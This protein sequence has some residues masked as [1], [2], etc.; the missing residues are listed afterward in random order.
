MAWLTL[1]GLAL[2]LTCLLPGQALAEGKLLPHQ[3]PFGG[4]AGGVAD[5]STFDNPAYYYAPVR[6]APSGTYYRQAG[7]SPDGAKIV[8][9]KSWNDGTYSRTEIV[10]MDAD[11]SDE[12]VISPGDSGQ[13]DIEQYGNPF[14]SDDG[15][16]VGYVE[17]HSANPNKVVRYDLATQTRAYI[18]E[19]VSPLDANNAD[20]L[21]ASTS[22]LVFWDTGP[23]TPVQYDLFTWD[24]TTRVNI[25]NSAEYK[26]YEPVSNADGTVIVYWSGET[27]AE[28][29]NT[30]HTLTYAGGT[31]TKDVGFSPIS[32]SY[33]SGW[34]GKA[35]NYIATTV[36]SSKDIMI[37][38]SSGALVTDLTGSGYSGGTGQWN[39]FGVLAEGPS[40]NWV[41]TSNAA[42]GATAGRDIVCAASRQEMYVAPPPLG[43]DTNCGTEAA[44]F[45]TVQKGVTEVASGGTVHV[46]AGTYTDPLLVDKSLALLGP[47][48]AVNP[49]TGARVAEAVLMGTTP[50]GLSNF[51]EL[52]AEDVVIRGFTFDNLRIDN[53]YG[54]TGTNSNL[55]GG[56]VIENNIFSDV[57]G[58][59]IYLRDG[60]DAPGLYSPDVSIQGNLIAAPG[61]AGSLD[62]QAGSGIVV[63]GAEASTISGNVVTSAAYNG[64]QLAR[65]NGMSVAD[66]TATGCAQPALQIAQWNDGTFTITGN[67]FST[68]STAKAAIRLYGFTNNYYP[69]FS[70]TGNT[71]QDSAYGA[72]IG[73]GDPGKGYNDIRDADYSFSGNTFSNVTN[74]RLIVYLA[75]EA[76][77][78]ELAEMDALFEQ[79]YYP[80]DSAQLITSADPFTYVVLHPMCS[81]DCYVA[82]TGN[83]SASG[84]SYDPFRTVQKGVDT[85]SAGGT[86]HVAAG[87]Y[88][89]QVNIGKSLS[90]TGAG[91][92]T[93]VKSPATLAPYTIG[94]AARRPIVYVH[95][96]T[97]TVQ[98]LTVDGDGLGNANSGFMGIAYQNAAGTIDS[99]TITRVRNTPLDGA[100]YGVGLYARNEDSAPRT[101]VVSNCVIA[102][103]QKN[104]TAF[105]GTGL[106]VDVHTNTITGHGA[107]TVTAQ[108]GIQV[109]LGATGTV[110][111]NNDIA[112]VSYT[113]GTWTASG[114]L[115]EYV[116]VDVVDNTLS[117]CQ[118][119]VYN[120]G[121]SGAISG[122]II[123]ASGTGTGTAGHYGVIAADPPLVV[124]SP[125]EGGEE[126]SGGHTS[127]SSEIDIT[128]NTLTGDGASTGSIG[129]W[130]AAGYDAND[131]ALNATGNGITDWAYGIVVDQCASDCGAGTL[132]SLHANDNCISGSVEYG[133][134]AEGITSDL[135]ASSNWWGDATGP[136][137]PTKNAGGTGDYVSDYVDFE[138]WVT[139]GCH[140]TV[141]SGHWKNLRTGI[142]D[143]L[144]GS[145][146]VAAT[147][148]TI[149]GVCSGTTPIP[150]GG[151]ADVANVTIDLHGC[152]AGPGSSFV[153]V[154]A[155]D[156]MVLGPGVLD[157]AGSAD[158]AI[159]VEAGAGNFILQGVEVRGWQDGVFVEGSV[160]SFKMGEN[161][162]H[163][164]TGAALHV[165]T[166]VTLGGVVTVEG[167]LFKDNS[168]PG[169]LNE[170]ATIPLDATYNSWGDLLGPAGPLGDGVGANVSFAP[171]TFAELFLDM[172]PDTE[173]VERH[174][175]EAT[176]FDIKLKADAAKLYGMTF[177]FT[178]DTAKLTLGTT[179]FA[180]PWAG[181]C[182][183]LPGLPAGAIGYF[184][185]LQNEVPPDPEWDAD[186]GTIATFHFTAFTG[187]PGDGPWT[188]LFDISHLEVD[189]GASAIGGQK[190]FINNAGFNDPTIPERD[191]TDVGLDDG[192]IIIERLAS[193]AGY[194]DLQ[195]RLNDSLAAVR[196]Y[197]QALKS[198]AVELANGTSAS[199]GAY[200]TVAISPHWLGVGNTY[201]LAADRWLYLPT[202]PLASPSFYNSRLLD[203]V[204]STLLPKAFL[205]GGD[206][207]NNEKIDI[208]DL[209]CIGGDYNRRSGFNLCGGTG[210]SDVNEDN[211]VNV[212][213]LS[214][215]G[216][217]LYKEHSPWTV[218]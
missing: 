85:V 14:W 145:L 124:P 159:V 214:M 53:Y 173:A 186:G 200:T 164:N 126:G 188:A 18:Y 113:P 116:D 49:N 48:A 60:R 94:G 161:F 32:D 194:V 34:S 157:G 136:Y 104:A 105:L 170:G 52:D 9:Q 142:F 109:G 218:P 25:T 131:L 38:D 183:V 115:L 40:G 154:T 74:H 123:S 137:H 138:P 215:A 54:T 87:T 205:L 122:N 64:I 216:G 86:V 153:T 158:P 212:Q 180:A 57:L 185:S 80:G 156:V 77:T 24:G 168:G 31:W 207:T 71:I 189:T 152:V 62:Y 202:T 147:G 10:L 98:Q 59:A 6:V 8:A 97:V 190:V 35:D 67:T 75:S 17:A 196:V 114:I 128:N 148:D 61:S 166:G 28:P 36:M 198:G 174:V 134:Y 11:G 15:T 47:N 58:T 197:N 95:G 118:T 209:S 33:W 92:G 41:I 175:V 127:A 106:A 90:L 20:F 199:S 7:L 1:V 144:A 143:D 178:Y 149:Q 45:A 81:T 204:P 68:L 42:R 39:F 135:D 56:V 29:I 181:R 155:N 27:T 73:H 91:A 103:F 187:T 99:V 176:G 23:G 83:D 133:M 51:L 208:G 44:P 4:E 13:G 179:T 65:C 69:V 206:A 22:A 96:A 46:A 108:N 100:Q 76:T 132:V 5:Y 72:Q 82:L 171:W 141:T 79:A 213:D 172:A 201:Y 26:E 182:T 203:G 167:N 165:G 50:S 177:V 102:D 125:Y 195:G 66:N 43:S 119:A 37:Y 169:V 140:G 210:L 12:T 160:V 88:V 184:C 110:G 151:T 191:I 89:E 78:E 2:A 120:W 63:L 84:N 3:Q 93:I 211:W 111:P 112:D 101:L 16:A 150:G 55:I 121:G 21:G 19:P 70:F 107:T 193:F 192:R 162:I 163:D 139:D 130:V 117:E 146:V 30:T 129:L 217:N